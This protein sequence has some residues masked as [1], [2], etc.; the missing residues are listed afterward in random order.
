MS[1]GLARKILTANRRCIPAHKPAADWSLRTMPA[2]M[3]PRPL[4]IQR[5]RRSTNQILLT[6]RWGCCC[7]H[8]RAALTARIPDGRAQNVDTNHTPCSSITTVYSGLINCCRCCCCCCCGVLVFGASSANHTRPARSHHQACT[9]TVQQQNNSKAM[10]CDDWR[11]ATAG[12]HVCG[13]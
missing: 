8:A 9:A 2:R 11:S 7:R 3:L 1:S 4:L 12:R 10:R 5:Q 13:Q 6:Q